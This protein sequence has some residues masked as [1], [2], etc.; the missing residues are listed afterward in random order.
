M[1]YPLNEIFLLL[2]VSI[3]ISAILSWATIRLAPHINLMDVPGSALHKIHQKP[4]PFTGGIVLIISLTIISIIFLPE[5]F[6]S[7]QGILIGAWIIFFFALLDD[8]FDLSPV[9]KLIGQIIAA[10]NLVNLGIKIQIFHSPEFFFHFK[11]F[12]TF[13]FKLIR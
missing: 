12:F 5:H 1:N 3:V 10:I 13:S 8:I 2:L 11:A 7:I 6:K 9:I 4:T